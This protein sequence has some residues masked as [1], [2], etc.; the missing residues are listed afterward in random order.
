MDYIEQVLA[1]LRHAS[2]QQDDIQAL[3]ARMG[4]VVQELGHGLAVVALGL[5]AQHIGT[6]IEEVHKAIVADV[7]AMIKQ[8]ASTIMTTDE[9]LRNV[10]QP[11]RFHG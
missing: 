7:A 5:P 6:F 3:Q 2:E 4:S 10:F 11:E 8:N 1:M 9:Y